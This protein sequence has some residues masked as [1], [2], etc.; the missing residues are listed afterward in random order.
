M[1]V[2]VY[3]ET[4]TSGGKQ[5][6]KALA[7]GIELFLEIV[8]SDADVH[9]TIGWDSVP[10][11]RSGEASRVGVVGVFCSRIGILELGMPS[12]GGTIYSPGRGKCEVFRP[13]R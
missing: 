10:L 5:R 11:F 1:A 8:D 13:E 9:P 2:F 3:Q 12:E 4:A 6:S 7:L